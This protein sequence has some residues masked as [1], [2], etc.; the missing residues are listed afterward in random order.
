[1]QLFLA[2]AL[3]RGLMPWPI[4][5]KRIFTRYLQ[6][7]WC[8]RVVHINHGSIKI[9]FPEGIAIEKIYSLSR[10]SL[11]INL[12]MQVNKS[13][14]W[15]SPFKQANCLCGPR[16]VNEDGTEQWAKIKLSLRWVSRPSKVRR[17]TI[18]SSKCSLGCS[19][20]EFFYKI[21]QS[22]MPVD[23]KLNSKT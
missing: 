20:F 9:F 7:T 5:S 8:S 21:F 4:R 19:G 10:P 13:I 23:A 6:I 17:E 18:Y 1:M 16:K 3:A 22:K 15:L 11:C 14:L 12:R 2:N